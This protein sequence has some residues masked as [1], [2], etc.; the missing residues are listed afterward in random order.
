LLD[1][2]K[3]A[4]LKTTWNPDSNAPNKQIGY[5]TYRFSLSE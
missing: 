1:P 5:I 4:A 3:L 2:A